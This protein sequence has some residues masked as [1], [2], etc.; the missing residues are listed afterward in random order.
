[1]DFVNKFTGGDQKT[2][3]QSSSGSE[4][5]K[6][7][8]GF[9]GGIGNKIN[10]AAGGGKEGEKNEDYLDKG[11]CLARHLRFGCQATVP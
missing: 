3:Q 7:G 8:G 10:E 11:E 6:E 5:K 2:E 4:D 9:F 1:M